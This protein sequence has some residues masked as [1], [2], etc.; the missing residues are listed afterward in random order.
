[1]QILQLL[2]LLSQDIPCS[3]RVRAERGHTPT[4]PLHLR[5]FEL[6]VLIMITT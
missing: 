3:V 1:M 4:H 2:H 5:H 6:S